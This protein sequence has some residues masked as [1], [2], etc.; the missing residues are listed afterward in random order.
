MDTVI[1]LRLVK[2]VTK[3]IPTTYTARAT[4]ENKA[5][6]SRP[7]TTA[8]PPIVRTEICF[9]E[10]PKAEFFA[11]RAIVSRNGFDAR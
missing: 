8:A 11:G 6:L 4:P 2:E 5:P 9:L 7:L 10:V 1:I 3:P